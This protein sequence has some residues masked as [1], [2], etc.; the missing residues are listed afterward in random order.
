MSTSDTTSKVGMRSRYLDRLQ[1]SV[2]ERPK[3]ADCKSAGTAFGGSNPPR[4]TRTKAQV[5]GVVCPL[6]WAFFAPEH[7]FRSHSSSHSSS[8]RKRAVESCG[9]LVGAVLAFG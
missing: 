3:G 2:P 4:P 6:V 9:G 7:V 5:R 8:Q 1:G